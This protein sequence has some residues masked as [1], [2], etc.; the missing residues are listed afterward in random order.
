MLSNTRR[1]RRSR[2]FKR[3]NQTGAC[4]LNNFV[5]DQLPAMIGCVDLIYFF[6]KISAL[7]WSQAPLWGGWGICFG[8]RFWLVCQVHNHPKVRLK[9]KDLQAFFQLRGFSY[10]RLQPQIATH[11]A[12]L[13]KAMRVF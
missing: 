5:V 4:R 1:D 7:T 13:A 10:S 2:I 11:V 9:T 12:T 8:S 6:R 3:Q